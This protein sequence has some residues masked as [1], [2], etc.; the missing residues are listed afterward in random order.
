MKLNRNWIEFSSVC[1]NLAAIQPT[2]IHSILKFNQFNSN[3]IQSGIEF[4]LIKWMIS[5]WWISWLDWF[6]CL[7]HFRSFFLA[8]ESI[9]SEMKLTSVSV[10]NFIHS[11]AAGCFINQLHS[12]FS[13]FN[14][15]SPSD[16]KLNSNFGIQ[17]ELSSYE[18][19]CRKKID[20]LNWNSE[21]SFERRVKL[22]A[23]AW[24]LNGTKLS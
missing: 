14:C 16:I 17:F 10:S 15:S 21:A 4:S 8:S 19:K 2:S 5:D 6:A 20:A 9:N 1:F 24:R 12:S 7:R 11:I 3:L 18:M 13:C 22:N 23:A